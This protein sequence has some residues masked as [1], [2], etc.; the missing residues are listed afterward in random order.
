[1]P[2]RSNFVNVQFAGSHRK[3]REQALV[4]WF[5]KVQEYVPS[6]VGEITYSCTDA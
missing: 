5:A 4:D 2:V 6:V 1:L 3:N